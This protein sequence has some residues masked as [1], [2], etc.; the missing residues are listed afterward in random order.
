MKNL[1][2]YERDDGLFDWRWIAENGEQQAESMQGYTTATDAHRGF[3][4]F[5]YSLLGALVDKVAQQADMAER[6]DG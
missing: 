1:D 5:V 2:I 6:I 4:S 3:V